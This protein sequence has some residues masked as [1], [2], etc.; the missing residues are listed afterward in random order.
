MSTEVYWVTVSLRENRS[1]EGRTLLTVVDEV[2]FTC[3]P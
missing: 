1:R 3:V 2:K